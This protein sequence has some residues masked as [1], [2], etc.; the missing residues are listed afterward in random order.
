MATSLGKIMT[1]HRF[2]DKTQICRHFLMDF[3]VHVV[4]C[5]ARCVLVSSRV[6]KLGEIDVLEMVENWLKHHALPCVV[7]PYPS[8]H[9]Y[10]SLVINK[11]H[12]SFGLA[13][14]CK[15]IYHIYVYIIIYMIIYV[16]IYIYIYIYISMYVYIL[17]ICIYTHVYIYI[18]I[19]MYLHIM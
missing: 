5:G 9:L 12:I 16:Y 15:W 1:N 3:F 14:A 8:D 13:L 10:S 17:Y 2:L 19:H 11:Y 18:Y 6:W 7:L 4:L